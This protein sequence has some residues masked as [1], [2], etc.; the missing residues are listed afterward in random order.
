[1]IGATQQGGLDGLLPSSGS[2]LPA[3]PGVG[4]ALGAT[5]LVS[6]LSPDLGG[7]P[8]SAGV[9]RTISIGQ[10]SVPQSWAAATPVANST[11]TPF[12]A[13]GSTAAVPDAEPGGMPGMPTAG[14]AAS[15][16]F[17]L[18]APRYGFK[19]TVMARPVVAG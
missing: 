19:P 12:P 16:G 8:V 9:G 14:S 2:L 17:G 10:L 3:G 15:R 4:S 18:V 1:M 7:A 6:Q 5:R 13:T 11:V